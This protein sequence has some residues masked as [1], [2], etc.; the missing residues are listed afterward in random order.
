M[1][2]L[3]SLL[4]NLSLISMNVLVTANFCEYFIF[5]FSLKDRKI[6]AEAIYDIPNNKTSEFWYDTILTA[7]TFFL[8]LTVIYNHRIMHQTYL[9]TKSLK[10][11]KESRE[12]CNT[13]FNPSC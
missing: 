7:H 13:P 4:G 9:F 10:A 3:I 5:F 12:L 2:L 6:M 8:P 1:E 11:F